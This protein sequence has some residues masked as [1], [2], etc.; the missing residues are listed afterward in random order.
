MFTGLVEETGRVVE[1]V[2]G[3]DAI[4]M[5]VKVDH[6]TRGL[7]KGDSLAVN[8]C[9]LT[10]TQIR[11]LK[12]GARVSF[13]L[14]QETW[15]RTSFAELSEGDPV[16]LERSLRAS[17]RLGGHFVTGHVD[18]VGRIRKLERHGADHEL[19]IAAPRS[20][21]DYVVEKGSIAVDGIS[22]TVAGVGKTWFR[23]WIIP[24]T[25][26]VTNLFSKE[27]GSQVNLE[28]DLIGK[29]VRQ[30]TGAYTKA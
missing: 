6:C 30:F 17:D 24:H 16:N 1:I 19:I 26:K 12:K 20:V 9:C 4:R 2:R 15:S 21:L 7:K 27:K 5:V 13:D 22:L 18:A 11:R 8:G 29:Y 14:L 28:A 25:M 23:L 3:A 10:A